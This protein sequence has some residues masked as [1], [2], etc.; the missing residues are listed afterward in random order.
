VSV[1]SKALC[2]VSDGHYTKSGN[3]SVSDEKNGDHLTVMRLKAGE[4]DF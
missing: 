1:V 2:A 3:C 4:H